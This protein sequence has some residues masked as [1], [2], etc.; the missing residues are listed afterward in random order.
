MIWLPCGYAAHLHE[1]A[2]RA[3]GCHHA[4]KML[5]EIPAAEDFLE[6]TPHHH[7]R[8]PPQAANVVVL[9]PAAISSCSGTTDGVKEM[10]YK[11]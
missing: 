1:D 6:M 11:H 7:H 3:V 5:H 2:Q 8:H 9:F 10:R 4:V